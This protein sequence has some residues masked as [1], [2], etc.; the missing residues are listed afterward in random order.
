LIIKDDFIPCVTIGE[1]M[2]NINENIWGVEKRAVLPF[3]GRGQ[4]GLYKL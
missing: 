1:M 3:R 4:R 2:N